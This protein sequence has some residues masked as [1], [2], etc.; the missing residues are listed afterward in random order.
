[1]KD[2][3]RRAQTRPS[4]QR[5]EI[6]YNARPMYQFILYNNL[7]I[8]IGAMPTSDCRAATRAAH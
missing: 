3:T 6:C 5:A 4:P 1:M 2:A 8:E 7:K